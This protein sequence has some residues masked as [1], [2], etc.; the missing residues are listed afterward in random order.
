MKKS[1]DYKSDKELV[2]EI[3]SGNKEKYRLIVERYS[4]M[5]FHIVRSFEKNE[6]EVSELGQQIFVKAYEKLDSFDGKSAFSSWLYSVARYHCLDHAKNVRRKNRRF[7]EYD[8]DFEEQMASGE[9]LPD[10]GLEAVELRNKLTFALDKISRE[11]SEPLLMKYRDGMA[12]ED[13]SERLG[14]SVPALKVRVHRAR[15]ELK[16]WIEN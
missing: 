10:S 6:E 1:T 5:I 4:P 14:V 3:V 15:K 11:Y 2:D 7:S 8:D 12:Y 16:Y 13:M 9:Y